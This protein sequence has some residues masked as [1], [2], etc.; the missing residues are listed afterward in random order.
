L[1]NFSDNVFPKFQN[2][3][4][5]LVERHWPFHIGFGTILTLAT[6]YSTNFF[7]NGCIFGALFPFFIISSCLVDADRLTMN[8]QQQQLIPTIH[9]Y[10]IAQNITNKI[11]VAIFGRIC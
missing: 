4:L 2:H 7:I 5:A 6:S 1:E 3:R 10:W 8:A 11:S 9:F